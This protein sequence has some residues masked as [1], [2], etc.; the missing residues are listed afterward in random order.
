MKLI[1]T[2]LA[3]AI[4]CCAEAADTTRYVIMFAGNAAGTHLVWSNSATDF[5]F[6]YEFNDRGRGPRLTARAT[7]NSDNHL[8][9][10][11][12]KGYDYF[13]AP[14]NE[15]FEVKDGMASWSNAI[16]KGQKT[17]EGNPIY[18][19]LDGTPA[20][21][22]LVLKALQK[23]PQHQA[24]L[25][26]SGS[27]KAVHIKNHTSKLEG[28]PVE[29]ELWAFNGSGGPP[30]YG[31]FT[32]KKNFFATVSN[33]VS[34]VEVGYESLVAELKQVQDVAE[35]DY[36]VTLAKTLTQKQ[37]HPILIENVTIFDAVTG[38]NKSGQ[39][40]LINN[41]VIEKTGKSKKVKA[42]SN[43]RVISGAGKTL[44]PGLWDNHTHF[45][46]TQG[47]Y[48]LAAGVTNIKDMANAPDLP[49]VKAKVDRDELLGPDI[50]V[51]SGFID[52]AGP[53]AGPGKTVKTLDEGLQ[54]V[55]YYADRG[56]QQIKLYSSIPPEW[57]KPLAD[58]A[59]KLGMKT[60]GH[61]PSFMTAD[62]A[63]RDGYDEIIHMNM[64]LL[65]FL[66]D[67]L[68]TRSMGRFTKVGERAGKIDLGSQ[69]VKDFIKLLQEKKIVVDPTVAIFENMFTDVPGKTDARFETSM[70][71]LPVVVARNA[72]RGGLPMMKGNEA[73]YRASF[74]KML[75]MVKVLRDNKI[76]FVPGTDDFPGFTLHRELELYAKAGVPNAEVLK[77][78]TLT[79]AQVAKLDK[80]FGSIEVG[81]R[82]NLILVDGDPVRN[83]SDVRQVVLTMKHGNLYDPKA[84][85]QSYG[86]G[87]WKQ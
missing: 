35:H 79:S 23:H 58:E 62:R 76:P 9:R 51:M 53:F 38:K 87:F 8:I 73:A 57:V 59:H 69:A 43:A 46:V 45:D 68:D 44:L 71:W 49:E 82:A 19:P 5:G 2:L 25:L 14:V 55:K 30:N 66:G 84:L 86:F 36:F 60:V 34:I 61:V 24:A 85:Y 18:A 41:G 72:K 20:E 50:S 67:T 13:K 32:P 15:V 54:A 33:W 26:P 1:S 56:Y 40:V 12:V 28:I 75:N 81:K 31:W 42:P 3:C 63:V 21:M 4:F 64:V 83:I 74:D 11:E 77:A 17:F 78:A 10:Y 39:S 47:L 65:N 7:L 29:L 70:S 80:E 27:I 22:Q 6:F 52:F 16:E 37:S 48:H